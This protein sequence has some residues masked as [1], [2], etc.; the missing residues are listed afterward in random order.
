MDEMNTHMDEM[1]T[2]MDE[3]N[4]HMDEMNTHLIPIVGELKDCLLIP[5]TFN[6]Y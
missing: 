6:P 4:T 5:Q 2:H 3:M 1:N